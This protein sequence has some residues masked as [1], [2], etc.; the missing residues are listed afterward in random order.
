[1]ALL[2]VT[3]QPMAAA[4]ALPFAPGGESNTVSMRMYVIDTRGR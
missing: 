4:C 1:M 3:G 2:T